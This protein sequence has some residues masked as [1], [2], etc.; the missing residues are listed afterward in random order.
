MRLFVFLV[1]A[2]A[3]APTVLAQD[4]RVLDAPR[5]I[6]TRTIREVIEASDLQFDS[7]TTHYV[8]AKATKGLNQLTIRNIHNAK[9]HFL[10]EIRGKVQTKTPWPDDRGV[11]N[12]VDCEDIEVSGLNVHNSQQ[13][14]LVPVEVGKHEA[15]ALNISRC[16]NLLVRDSKFSG[17]GKGIVV[18]HSKSKVRMRACEITGYYLEVQVGASDVELE[19]VVCHQ[20]NLLAP[21]SHSAL[22]VS[23]YVKNA[24]NRVYKGTN[25][26]LKGMTFNLK[27]G[28]GIVTG[29]GS[30]DARSTLTFEDTPRI[31][32][33]YP[34]IGFA[35]LHR[36][37]QCISVVLK[38]KFPGLVDLVRAKRKGDRGVGR[39]VIYHDSP[40]R[41]HSESP[42]VVD[43]LSSET[44][45]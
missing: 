5:R 33:R 26:S 24:S 40:G 13:Y 32:H 16:K 4:V 2:L 14:Q 31:N 22:Y 34:C 17:L 39:F 44:I 35:V 30:L 37:Y 36:N 12:F 45:P 19:D 27:T 6:K 8:H 15:T 20:E 28:R 25:I 43:G 11:V 3:S 38:E 9:I 42:I 7:N 10:G 18:I 41:P 23:S 29:S 1:L 21:D